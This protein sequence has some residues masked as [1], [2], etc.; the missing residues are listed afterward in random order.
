[1]GGQ[2]AIPKRP[3]TRQRRN[4]QRD[5]VHLAPRREVKHPPLPKHLKTPQV[6]AMWKRLWDS[7][8]APEYTEA[9]HDGLFVYA[10]LIDEFYRADV[11]PTRRLEVAKEIR[12]QRQG[13]GLT[14]LDRRRLQWEV[15][16]GDEAVQ[17][18]Q[19]RKNAAKPKAVET[20]DDPRAALGG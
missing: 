9:D 7:E 20:G 1:M 10:E 19:K 13:Y 12:L 3:S 2:G 18:T 17:K 6:K 11:S 16:R 4:G 8:M 14:P 15:D 5:I